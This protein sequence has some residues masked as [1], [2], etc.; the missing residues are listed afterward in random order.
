MTTCLDLGLDCQNWR[1]TCGLHSNEL[2][3]HLVNRYRF[4]IK[5][6]IVVQMG[7][8]SD[9]SK[10]P[11]HTHRPIDW[12]V[13]SHDHFYYQSLVIYT[14]TKEISIMTCIITLLWRESVLKEPIVCYHLTSFSLTLEW[15]LKPRRGGEQLPFRLHSVSFKPQQPRL[16][17]CISLLG[18]QPNLL[19][20]A[21]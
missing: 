20:T 16:S 14:H 12:D 10:T 13:S 18:E 8:H 9:Y 2:F 3:P 4:G 17:Y 11:G 19:V 15:D 7:V 21:I 1:L 6:I 5:H